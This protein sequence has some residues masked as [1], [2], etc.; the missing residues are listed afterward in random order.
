MA[1][2]TD[3]DLI[4]DQRHFHVRVEMATVSH[5]TRSHALCRLSGSNHDE[6]HPGLVAGHV[7]AILANAM[8][9]VV[10]TTALAALAA[11]KNRGHDDRGADKQRARVDAWKN[12]AV[13]LVTATSITL[14]SDGITPGAFSSGGVAAA[15]VDAVDIHTHS[16]ESAQ[17]AGIFLSLGTC[18]H[19]AAMDRVEWTGDHV[20]GGHGIVFRNRLETVYADGSHR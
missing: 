9:L 17:A 6:F 10:E 14:I 1:R 12:A 16:N 15:F 3:L 13:I 19:A 2:P 7:V 4:S 11:C 5:I 18:G 8:E 20:A